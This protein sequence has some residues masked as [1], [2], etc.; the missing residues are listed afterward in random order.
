MSGID[1]TIRRE[2]AGKEFRESF[3][4]ENA[5]RGLAYQIR[6]L[7]EA[8]GWTQAEFARQAQ[9]PQSNVYR[10]E[11]PSYGKFNISTLIEIASVF[12]VALSIRFVGFEELLS[13]L[14]DLRP[15]TLAVPNYK[16]E[17]EALAEREPQAAGGALEAFYRSPD[18]R[19]AT[20]AANA[21]LA[22]RPDLDPDIRPDISQL[23]AP[24]E[25]VL[26][27]QG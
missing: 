27:V 15:T 22:R 17:L 21:P 13:S 26:R 9:K 25:Q 8:R 2:L 18:Q 24:K 12:D 11:D 7:R 6:A 4:G 1:S 23:A 5:R 14:S 16:V 19:G 3:V 10:W 20:P